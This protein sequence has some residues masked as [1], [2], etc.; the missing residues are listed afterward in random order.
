MEIQWPLAIFTALEGAAGWLLVWICVNEF[1]GKT[2]DKDLRFKQLVCAG[3][4]ALVGGLAVTFHLTHVDRIMGAL[5]HPAS[6][7]FAEA[8]A[9]GITLLVIIIFIVLARRDAAKNTLK[10]MAVIGA[11]C[12]VALSFVTGYGYVMSSQP[13]WNTLLM[14]ICYLLTGA[15]AGSAI[16]LCSIAFWKNYEAETSA[17]KAAA[18]KFAGSTT[19]ISGIVAAVFVTIYA[20]VQGTF[21]VAGAPMQFVLV[22]LGC[23]GAAACGYFAVKRQTTTLSIVGVVCGF[24][25]VLGF[26]CFMFVAGTGLISLIYNVDVVNHFFA[27]I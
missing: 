13:N 5:S 9:T 18:L 14:P 17:D 16:Y 22:L 4:I 21:G 11:V 12:G 26:R 3:V 2:D 24:V 27:T 23:L 8:L 7:I 25:G 1:T 10:A 19:Y 15:V 20:I 6:P